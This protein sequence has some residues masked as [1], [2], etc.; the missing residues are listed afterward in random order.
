M[1]KVLRS[2]KRYSLAVILM[3][4]IAGL[5]SA[6]TDSET[7]G[8]IL[9]DEI[10]PPAVAG[11]QVRQYLE[12]RVAP[13]PGATSAEQW[14][15]QAQ[16][17]RQQMVDVAY[18]G[19]PKDWVNSPLKF[20]DL[21]VIEGGK[22]YKL[23]KLRYEIVP[24]F[25][26]TAI[27]YEPENLQGKVTAVLNVHGH[28]GPPGKA[29]EF[30]QKRCIAMAKHGI[31]ALNLEWFSFGE[32]G[33]H[34]NE[35]WFGAHLDLVG[36]NEMGL[37]YL[38]MRRGLDYLYDHPHVDRNR[39]AVTGLSGGGWQTI[40]LS[41]LDERVRVSIPVAGFSSI[42]TRVEV[43][44]YGDLGDVEQSA[45]DLYD[46]RD[47]MHLAALMAP[48]PTLL[49]YNA[50]DDCCFRAPLVK[51]LIFEG[52]KPFFRLYG[53]ESDLQWHE[54]RDPGIHNYQLDNRLSAY[55]FLS[56][57]FD[58][59]P[60]DTEAGVAQEI[61][62][63]DELVVGL[64][65]D[66][67]TILGLAQRVGRQITRAEAPADSASSGSWAV[68]ERQKLASVVHSQA[69]SITST[70]VVANTKH[71]GVETKSYLFLMSNGLNAGAVWLKAIHSP[72]N[73]PLTIVLSDKGKKGAGAE[74]AERVNRGTLEHQTPYHVLV[75]ANDSKPAIS[76]TPPAGRVRSN[77]VTLSVD[78]QARGKISS[79]R[80][81]YKRMPAPY[82]WLKIEM[83]PR[84]GTAYSASVPLTPEGILYYFEAIDED[85][86]GVNYPDIMKRTPYLTVEAWAPAETIGEV[87]GHAA[88]EPGA[89]NR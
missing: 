86:N 20:E 39:L 37:F 84:G 60:I 3:H 10:I 83:Q 76:H 26:S 59:P 71:N 15:A 18:H 6:Q 82:E 50:E 41:A 61:K 9:G 54:N 79:V 33:A 14:T 30:K 62:S 13:P 12:N 74:V 89:G 48:R 72:D 8:P 87:M 78:V 69:A 75:T 73:S 38:A 25:Q 2:L 40:L 46:G 80:V 36:M 17:L 44:A 42:R 66:N 58:L 56:K 11:F 85:G 57:Q 16:K 81:Y 77:A 34:E 63:Y 7:L 67:L 28:V 35:H 45:T 21:G 32:L 23:R 88:T 29:V 4:V 1:R 31:L 51:L 53:K 68:A 70:W 43:R 52:T 47:Y 24:S 55:A 19:W 49:V 64:P 5:A 27:L 22:G 65:K